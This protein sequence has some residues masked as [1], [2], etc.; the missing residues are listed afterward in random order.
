MIVVRKKLAPSSGAGSPPTTTRP[1]RA[2]A[3]STS[4]LTIWNCL[5]FC[6]GPST[7]PSSRP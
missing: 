5:A 3:S 4:R 7:V 1:P 2:F 6:S